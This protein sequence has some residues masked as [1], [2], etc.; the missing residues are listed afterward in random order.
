MT[1]LAKLTK[2]QRANYHYMADAMRRLEHDLHNAI[3]LSN[4]V[5]Q[6][7]HRIAETRRPGKRRRVTMRIEEEVIRFFKSMGDG[8][9]AR[10]N[11][12][13]R[14]W[15]HGRLAGVIRGAETMDYYK[16]GRMAFA[17][18]KPGWGETDRQIVETMGE[19]AAQELKEVFRMLD[20]AERKGGRGTIN[21]TGESGEATQDAS[22]ET[23][24]G[25]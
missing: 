11:D 19:D 18:A 16:E 23:R 4:K 17:G 6:D 8:Y 12:V 3:H 22:F 7:W 21:S 1:D 24:A 5:P 10:M 20:E 14:A 9:Q 25:K 15:M 2:T 13:L